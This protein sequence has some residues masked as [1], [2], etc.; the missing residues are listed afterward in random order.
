MGPRALTSSAA[1]PL[2]TLYD[3]NRRRSPDDDDDDDVDADDE[4]DDDGDGD[5][6][7]AALNDDAASPQHNTT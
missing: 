4:N 6:I 5:D 7:G 3:V 2:N 1:L